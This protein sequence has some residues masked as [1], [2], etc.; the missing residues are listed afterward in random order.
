MSVRKLSRGRDLVVT[1]AVV[2]ATREAADRPRNKNPL[3]RFGKIQAQHSC[4][5][6]GKTPSAS[7]SVSPSSCSFIVRLYRVALLGRER[8]GRLL[9]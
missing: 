7:I 9:V 8:R 4:A 2:M 5:M 1:V 6:A 3:W